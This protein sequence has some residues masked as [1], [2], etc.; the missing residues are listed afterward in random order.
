[1][2]ANRA[3]HLS[4]LDSRPGRVTMV[5]DSLDELRGPE[6]GVVELP[7]RLLW[8]P[9][10]VVDLDDAWSR[11]WAYAAILREAATVDDLRQWV[12]ANVLRRLWPGLNL[13]RGVRDTWETRHPELARLRSAY[14]VADP[15]AIRKLRQRFADWPR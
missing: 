13:P 11:E 10:R 5:T 14:G 7:N 3:R 12:N 4:R 6:R 15:S 2:G 8:R 9:N 1:M